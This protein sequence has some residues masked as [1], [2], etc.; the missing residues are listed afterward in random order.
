MGR[1]PVL[2]LRC[3]P[4]RRLRLGTILG[5]RCTVLRLLRVELL[6]LRLRL[7]VVELLLLRLR[8]RLFVVELWLL[9]LFGTV[10]L[11]L[12]WLVWARLLGRNRLGGVNLRLVGP[13]VRLLLEWL[14]AGAVVGVEGLPGMHFGLT[15]SYVLLSWPR[16]LDLRLVDWC[17]LAVALLP[18]TVLGLARSGL[19]LT[20]TVGGASWIRSRVGAGVAWLRG[21]WARGCDHGRTAFVDV[22]E[23][24]AILCSFALML[25]LGGHWR[26]SGAAHGFDFGRARSDG[27]AS[28]ASV[29]SDAGVVVDDYGVLINVADTGA[30][31]VDGAVVIEVVAAPVAAVI[32]DAGVAKAVVDAAVEADVGTPKAA[33]EAPAIVI[34]TPVT[35][36]PEGAVVR[37]SAPGAGNPVVAGGSPIPVAGCPD[38][39]GR[40]GFW[41]LVDG[42]GWRRLVGVFDGWCFTFLVELINGLRVL[43]GLVVLIGRWGTGLLG[44]I[45]LWG[46]G[47]LGGVL[48]RRILLVT[49]LRLGLIANSKYSTLSCGGGRWLRRLVGYWSQVGVCGIRTRVSGS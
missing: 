12:L 36:S 11:P 4:L 27:D 22:V 6:L 39:V 44:W 46:V 17:A 35:W 1:W 32:T 20:G 23:L 25:D 7:L 15:G 34:P 45:L 16:R 38:I 30:D 14:L 40:G 48:L 26:D 3:R 33:M 31:A 28:S 37:R 2:G 42:Q 43:I 8:L 18:R 29:V 19:R 13:A 10:L 49:L 41:L 21:D 47:L 24:L 9:R 5:L